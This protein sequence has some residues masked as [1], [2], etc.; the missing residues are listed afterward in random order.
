MTTAT[1]LPDV[2]VRGDAL[3]P[4]WSHEAGAS[5]L[6]LSLETRLPEDRGQRPLR[7][8]LLCGFTKTH[9]GWRATG[10]AVQIPAGAAQHLARAIDDGADLMTRRMQSGRRE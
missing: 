1:A 10:P 5:K 7:T 2:D 3:E 6:V 8:L 9:T 4:L